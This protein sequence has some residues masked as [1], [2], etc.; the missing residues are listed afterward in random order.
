MITALEDAGFEILDDESLRPHYAETLRR[1]AANHD[2]HREEAI[3]EIGAERERVWRLHNVGAALGVRARQAVRPPGARPAAGGLLTAA[4]AGALVPRGRL[5]ALGPGR[6][7]GPFP[8]FIGLSDR[9][10]PYARAF[11]IPR[12][13]F[14]R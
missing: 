13:G 3:A 1:W 10:T 9:D 6:N 4:A 5:I 11:L 12:G 7:F 14:R 2:A 8:D